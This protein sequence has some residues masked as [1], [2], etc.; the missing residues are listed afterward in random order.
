VLEAHADLILPMAA[1]TETSGT[2][3]NAWGEWQSFK[4]V[5]KPFKATRPA[6][7][8]LRALAGFLQLDGFEYESSE[9]VKKEVKSTLEKMP[10][11]RMQLKQPAAFNL[12]KQHSALT[13]IGEIPIYA[14]DSIVRRSAP[15]QAAQAIMLGDVAAVRIH[16]ETAKKLNVVNGGQ[17]QVKQSGHEAELTVLFDE[18]IAK[19]A[20]WL[21]G[22]IPAAMTLGNLFG[23]IEV[24]P[25]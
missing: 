18:Q 3:V 20:V 5:A 6:W 12:S 9:E 19:D 1:F 10:E 24:R 21:A 4:G 2:F 7:K 25:C 23:E 16:P 8:I 14:T 11:M 22:S 17:V 15:L 13:R